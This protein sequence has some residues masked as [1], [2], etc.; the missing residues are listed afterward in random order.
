MEDEFGYALLIR[1]KPKVIPTPLGR[2]LLGPIKRIMAEVDNL[3]HQLGA[4]SGDSAR[5]FI[6]VAGSAVGIAY[7]YGDYCHQFIVDHPNV[8]L[9]FTATETSE[10]AVQKVT[11]G[12][13]DIGFVP[14]GEHMNQLARLPLGTA[15]QILIVGANHKLANRTVVSIE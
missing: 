14:F 3:E 12:E 15:E 1:T 9:S 10:D 6:R 5:Q 7:L 2:R 8:D 11:A 13:A 4:P